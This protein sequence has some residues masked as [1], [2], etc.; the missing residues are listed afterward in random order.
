M[1]IKY[2]NLKTE[3]E[4]EFKIV[5][6][7]VVQLTGKLPTT[8]SGF[9]VYRNDGRLIGTYATFTT[10]HKVLEDGYQYSDDGS[11]HIEPEVPEVLEEVTVEPTAEELAEQE[12][13]QRIVDL[14]TH[15][16]S[17]NEKLKDLGIKNDIY[18]EQKEL[19]IT[20]E[21]TIEEIYSEKQPIRDQIDKLETELKALIAEG[22]S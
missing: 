18:D 14:N 19:G 11:I 9:K 1:R 3:Y 2:L 15:I 22:E 12:R 5:S 6:E 20:S 8:G 4:A 16:A 10:V 13:Q 21:Y 17:L 7:H